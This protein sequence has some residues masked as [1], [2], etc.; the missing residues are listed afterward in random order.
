MSS[1][2]MMATSAAGISP[3]ELDGFEIGGAVAGRDETEE[4]RVD[5][6]LGLQQRQRQ[7]EFAERRDRDVG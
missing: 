6:G 3:V 1:L 4:F 5:F 7:K 2:N